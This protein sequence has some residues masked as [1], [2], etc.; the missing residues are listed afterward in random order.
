MGTS[1]LIITFRNTVRHMYMLLESVQDF[2][3]V[4]WLTFLIP[5]AVVMKLPSL[6]GF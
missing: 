6:E 3:F 4:V 1:C 5:K 2:C